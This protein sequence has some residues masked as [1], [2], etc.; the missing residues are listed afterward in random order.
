MTTRLTPR[1]SNDLCARSP[2]GHPLVNRAG[3]YR[4]DMT[5]EEFRAAGHQLIDWVADHRARI[6]QLPVQ[7]QVKPGDVARALPSTP[8]V[9]TE[10][11]DLLLD[12]LERLIV[13]GITQVQHPRHFGWFPSN[14]T[15]ASVLGDLASGGLGALGITWQ[16]APAL[17][18][19][20]EVVTDWLRQLTGL[21]PRWRGAIHDTASTACLVA[22]LA[23]RERVTDYCL[24]RGG[25][26]AEP[27]PLIVYASP[28]AHS[29][30]TKAVTLSGYGRDNLRLIPVDPVSQA[31][32][33]QA[34]AEA[35]AADVAAGHRPAAVV[36]SV[37]T[38]GTTAV[39]PLAEILPIA[40]QHGMWVHVDA[41]MAGAALLLPELRWLVAGLDGV[42]QAPEGADSLSWNPHKWL[43]TILDC[44]LLY[45][46]DPEHLIRV[47]ST[48]PSYLRSAVDGEVTQYKDWGIP[49]GRRFRALKLWFQL[50]LDGVEAIQARLRR[51]LANARWLAEQVA[52]EP[53][54][55]VLAPVPL[56]TVCLR[57]E[58]A[59]LVAPDGT[60]LDGAAL[61]A[62][63]LSWVDA[64]NASGLAFLTPAQ[65]DGRWMAR[66]SIGAEP[67]ERADVEALWDLIR[68]TAADPE[69]GSAR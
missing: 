32:R 16:S 25:L 30:V 53:G 38:T 14:A 58:P 6:A 52:T 41:A 33:P 15:L 68:T 31:M 56:Q 35:V 11:I 27:A 9:E 4:S 12:D 7:A 65:L 13:P 61:D 42:P 18:E 48:N 28:H 64:V 55:R 26:Q 63:T 40:Q 47:M 2:A 29:S 8:P 57:H 49:L 20:E 51:D 62:H 10:P 24:A 22:L 23:A 17:T 37:G 54:W 39:D 3:A 50:R 45:V 1:A 46:R 34:L 59:G 5:P 19:L 69:C 21:S 44:S 36:V 60:V 43:G 67:T 66:I